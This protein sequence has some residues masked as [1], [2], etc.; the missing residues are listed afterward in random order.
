MKILYVITKGNW[1]GAQRYL[2][3][4]ATSLPQIH[5]RVALVGEGEALKR[6]LTDAGVRVILLSGLGRDVT[7][8]KDLITLARLV[9]LFR[10]ERPDVVHLNSAK[11]GGLGALA[12]RLAGIKRIVFTAHGFASSEDRPSWQRALIRLIECLT[13][14]LSHTTIC[15]SRVDTQTAA[16]L[17][18]CHNKVRHIKLGI[19]PISF[20]P[21]ASARAAL[22]LSGD[23][24]TIGT[25]AELTKN[26]GLAYA[27]EAMKSVPDTRYI[28]VGDGELRSELARLIKRFNLESHVSLVGQVKDVATLLNAFDIFLLPSV[29]EGLPYTLLEA[30]LAGLPVIATSVGGVPDIIEDRETGLLVAPTHPSEIAQKLKAL[31][32]NPKLRETLGRNLHA[33]ATNYS[34]EQMR[35]KTFALYTTDEGSAP[36]EASF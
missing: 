15:V 35:A 17:P 32:A 14:L 31:L 20:A 8:F 30:G 4:L 10:K 12:A 23:G 27:I 33:V 18:F 7:L 16:R 11:I 36:T 5:E 28:I 1:G 6:R 24:L 22:N 29:K 25:V 3:D 9:R 26:K 21:R 34:I 13:I 2:F 19:G